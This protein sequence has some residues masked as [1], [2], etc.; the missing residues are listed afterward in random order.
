[1]RN[2]APKPSYAQMVA[3][4]VGRPW[5]DVMG[6]VV[7]LPYTTLSVRLIWSSDFQ[8]DNPNRL[9]VVVDRHGDVERIWWG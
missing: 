8:D 1:M 4:Y 5:D 2:R 9:N 6:S 7:A 3:D